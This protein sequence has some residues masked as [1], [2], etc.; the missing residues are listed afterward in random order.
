MFSHRSGLWW[1]VCVND[2][3]LHTK[4][5]PLEFVRIWS[6]QLPRPV[7]RQD[8]NKDRIA[9]ANAIWVGKDIDRI[10]DGRQFMCT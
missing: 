3:S 6:P 10:Q 2:V 8:G 7:D 5:D 4:G 1:D 9:F